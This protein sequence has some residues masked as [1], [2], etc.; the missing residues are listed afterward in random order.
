M[1][2]RPINQQI[3]SHSDSD[4]TDK[5]SIS[6]IE[7]I[8][9]HHK[10]VMPKLY[11]NDKWPN[12]DGHVE[13]QGA[14]KALIGR[15]YAQAKTLPQNH[16]LKFAC[17]VSFFSNCEIDPCLLFGVDNS[18][19]K[20]YWLYFDA[21]VVK[22]IDFR[23]NS[24]TKTIEFNQS[25]YFDKKNISYVDAWEKI[26]LNNQK[27]FKDYNDLKNSYELILKSS[28]R[29]IGRTDKSFSKI[30]QFLD[31]LNYGLDHQYQIVKNVFYPNSWKLG[32]A[33][34]DYSD[35]KIAYT[36]FPIPLNQND[37]QI[38]EVD[39]N[40]KNK[41]RGQGL[42]F[43]GHFVENPIESRPEEYAKEFLGSKIETIMG[44]QLLGHQGDE[45]LAQET[46][47]SFIENYHRQIG[48]PL[49]NSYSTA[50][51]KKS[52]WLMER[53]N[54]H[55]LSIDGKQINLRVFW[56]FF[57]YLATNHLPIKRVYKAKDF[58][59]I[60]GGGWIWNVFSKTDTQHNLDIVFAHLL[61]TYNI[62][63]NNNFPLCRDEFS[64][65]GSGNL[66]LVNYRLKDNYT[67]HASGPTYEMF[68]L[69]EI[70]GDSQPA[71]DVI[72]EPEAKELRKFVSSKGP[73]K[74]IYR[75][76]GYKLFS[77][78]HSV[79][80]FI[81]QDTPL[82]KLVYELLSRRIERYFDNR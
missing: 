61:E 60:P 62:L 12:I 66:I 58:S 22:G 28:N 65:F 75:N 82:L 49:K 77:S 14:N 31:E 1:S 25:Q 48:I 19:E 76:K 6:L 67:D 37:V 54:T 10:R 53:K 8:L 32:V 24:S 36:P 51:V 27:K 9:A 40:L 44:K 30:H 79:L 78:T 11:S 23:D 13:V 45:I 21:H 55:I 2:K 71:V 33:Y 70:G 7:N 74:F 29:V 5:E 15:L 39:D 59:R 52:R 72:G 34:Y 20:V 35:K 17:P 4:F 80:D 46:V 68:Y 81:Y 69:K 47:F 3:P 73:D 38:K 41:L 64:L 63:L 16:N 18:N 50:E 42:G 57:D 26:I 56:E 43:I